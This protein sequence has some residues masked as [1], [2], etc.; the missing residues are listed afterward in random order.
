[1]VLRQICLGHMQQKPCAK[2]KR[3]LKQELLDA[4][5][6]SYNIG[7]D[8]YFGWVVLGGITFSPAALC[9]YSPFTEKFIYLP[10]GLPLFL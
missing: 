10:P 7:C 3:V 5:V 1:M 4:T 8:P 9:L 6:D 2:I